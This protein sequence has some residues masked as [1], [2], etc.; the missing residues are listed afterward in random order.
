MLYRIT[1]HRVIDGAG[2]ARSLWLTVAH[3]TTPSTEFRVPAGILFAGAN[4]YARLTAI[5]ESGTAQT[6]TASFVP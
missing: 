5:S 6:V 2:L 1:L 4:Y 3:F